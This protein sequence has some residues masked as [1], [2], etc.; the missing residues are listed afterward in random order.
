MKIPIEVSAR[1]VHL[2]QKDLEMLFGR[3]YQLKK[4]RNL[5]QPCDFAA[6]ETINIKS[7]SRII[8]GLRVVGPIR[9]KTQVELSLTDAFFLEM[10]PP[11]RDSGNIE[12]TPGIILIGPKKE[13]HLKKGVIIHRRHIHSNQK[14]AKL[15]GIKNGEFVS[16]IIRGKRATTFHNIKV[17]V[18]K[19][20]KLCIHLDTDEGNAA[21]IIKKS[22]G[23]L[24]SS[25]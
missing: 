19:N 7:G 14:E 3:G 5:T 23:F 17:R 20:Y 2:C 22:E 18:N 16:V 11:I 4:L 9:K 6:K 21:G 24:V 8:P 1:H 15:L 10:N 25:I 13:I 12:K